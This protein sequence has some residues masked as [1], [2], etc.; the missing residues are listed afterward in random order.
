VCDDH[1]DLRRL[2]GLRAGRCGLGRY[3]VCTGS[4]AVP[5]T[6]VETVVI[7]GP[8]HAVELGAFLSDAK[9]RRVRLAAGRLRQLADLG[10]NWAAA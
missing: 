10:R 1:E 5:R 4:V 8:E 3:Q 7:G 9:T 2:W 6:H